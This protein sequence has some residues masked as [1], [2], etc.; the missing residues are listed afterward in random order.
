MLKLVQDVTAK[1]VDD[2]EAMTIDL[3]ELCRMAAQ[4]MLAV[5]RL[6]ERR[7]YLEAHGARARR[8]RPTPGGRQRVRPGPGGDDR[9][10][11]GRGRPPGSTTAARAN[12]SARPS[13]RP[14]CASRPR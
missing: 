3:D 1:V 14:T 2:P 7:A 8:R 10:R 11:D 5:A 4:E 12:G 6:A 13:C 9:G